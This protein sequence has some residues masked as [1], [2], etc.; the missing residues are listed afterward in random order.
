MTWVFYRHLSQNTILGLTNDIASAYLIVPP[1]TVKRINKAIGHPLEGNF[2]FGF[3]FDTHTL[4]GQVNY[5]D[6]DMQEIDVK[7]TY[8]YKHMVIPASSGLL[9]WSNTFLVKRKVY[10]DYGASLE[11]KKSSKA[12]AQKNIKKVRDW[13]TKSGAS[14]FA[15][16]ISTKEDVVTL[17]VMKDAKAHKLAEKGRNWATKSGNIVKATLDQL[18]ST[19]V[20]LLRKKDKKPMRIK[21]TDLSNEDI[22]FID[23]LQWDGEKQKHYRLMNCQKKIKSWYRYLV[24]K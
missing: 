9:Y 13:K 14:Y 6:V 24:L 22:L 8:S 3:K 18:G 7:D 11:E 21:L 5:M 16:Y 19:E 20:I 15:K 1:V 10:S 4:G 17:L 23:R 2:G 12:K